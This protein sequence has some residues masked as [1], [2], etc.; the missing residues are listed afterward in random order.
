MHFNPWFILDIEFHGRS[1]WHETQK[2]IAVQ[3]CTRRMQPLFE[4]GPCASMRFG[5]TPISENRFQTL[6]YVLLQNQWRNCDMCSLMQLVE[7]NSNHQHPQIGKKISHQPWTSLTSEAIGAMRSVL[8]GHRWL[9]Y[10]VLFSG[11]KI[12]SN[13]SL[14]CVYIYMPLL[15]YVVVFTE[16]IPTQNGKE[17]RT[18]TRSIEKSHSHLIPSLCHHTCTMPYTVDFAL[19]TISLQPQSSDSTS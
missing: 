1:R 16:R 12:I 9:F 5:S 19:P 18:W 2:S 4:T 17:I 11:F 13:I 6:H 14:I 8:S 10:Q 15:L 7:S 3:G